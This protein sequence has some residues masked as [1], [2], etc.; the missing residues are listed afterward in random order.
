MQPLLLAFQFLTRFPI[1]VTIEA[2]PQVVGRALLYYP[3]VGGV[4]GVGI[5]LVALLLPVTSGLMGAALC[6]LL[7]VWATGAL[8]LDGLADTADAW[9]GGMGDRAR[10]LAIMKDPACGPMGVTAIILLLLL[11]L[12]ALEQLLMQQQ[13][14]MLIGVPLLG[15]AAVVVLMVTTPYAR[16]GGMGEG[17]A[18]Y[19][20]KAGAIVSVMMA[21]T[22]WLF[23]TGVTGILPLLMLGLLLAR[24]RY[25]LIRRL[26]GTTG[27]TAGALVE[28]AELTLLVGFLLVG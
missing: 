22:L 21:V 26:G 6:L 4:M 5:W 16:P 17:S 19:A 12:A 1:P 13:L 27:D 25:L 11:K 10:T 2:T 14:L 24:W 28:M 8:H 7:W 20:P 3:L 9:V 23:M 18:L 15:R